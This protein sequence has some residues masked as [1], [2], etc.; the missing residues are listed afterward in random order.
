MNQKSLDIMRKL[1]KPA[2]NEQ[3]AKVARACT[4]PTS[5][6]QLT[7]A[8]AGLEDEVRALIARRKTRQVSAG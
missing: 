7:L 2:S 1:L 4:S 5:H 3:M 8:D 6:E